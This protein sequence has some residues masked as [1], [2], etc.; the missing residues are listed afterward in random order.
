MVR[1]GFMGRVRG[2]I[3]SSSIKHHSLSP[4]S[5]IAQPSGQEWGPQ[6]RPAEE[7]RE[8]VPDLHV[9]SDRLSEE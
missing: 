3:I 4:R 5:Y 9:L 2:V 7:R 1:A 6:E 8:P